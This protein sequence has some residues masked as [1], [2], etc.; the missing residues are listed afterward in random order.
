LPAQVHCPAPNFPT[1]PVV[2]STIA[3]AREFEVWWK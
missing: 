1:F 3:A 2:M